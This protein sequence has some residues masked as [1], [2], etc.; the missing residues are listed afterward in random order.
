MSKLKQTLIQIRFV[1]L[2]NKPFANLYHEVRVSGDKFAASAGKSN[3]KGLG[4]WIEKPVGTRLDILVR[5][6]LTKKLISAKH[7]VIVP[8]KKGVFR[9]QAPFSIQTVKLRALE[10][11]AG[12]YKRSTHKVESGT[13]DYKVKKGQDLYTI[14]KMHNTT[15]QILAQLNKATIKDPDKIFSGQIIKVPPKG[16][17]LTGTTNDR[18][19]S[20]KNQTHYKV[21]KG[22]TLSGISQ[23]SSVSVEELKRMNKITDPRTLQEGQTIKLRENGSAQSHTSPKPSPTSTAKPRPTTAPSSSAE[24]NGLFDGVL[25]T[26]TDIAKGTVGAIG[27]A[28]EW[29][30]D[31][32]KEGFEGVTDAMSGGKNDE[33]AG[34]APAASTNAKIKTDTPIKIPVEQEYS[35]KDGTPKVVSGTVCKDDPACIF[36]GKSATAA[37]KKLI[38]EVNIRLAGFGGALPTEEFTEL[39]ERCIKQFQ[40][41][42]M[43]APETGKICGSLIKAID[44]FNYEY[45]IGPY[46]EQMKCPCGQCSGF[47]NGRMGVPSGNN[48]ANEYPGIHRSII[49]AFKA[50]MFYL[51]FTNLGYKALLVSSGYRCIVRNAQKKRT[52][53]NHMGQAL[54]VQFSHISNG[55]IANSV[56]DVE[57]IREVVLVSYM[58]AEYRWDKKN[59][60]SLETTADGASSWVHF[61]SREYELKYKKLN[62]YAKTIAGII[63]GDLSTHTNNRML[64]CGG[65]FIIK[66]KSQSL[67]SIGGIV[68]KVI[69]SHESEGGRYDIFNRG[70]VGDYAWTSG[71]EDIGNRTIDEWR[72]LGTLSGDNKAKRFAMGKYQIIPDTLGEIQKSLKL[73]GSTKLTPETQEL[74]FLEHFIKKTNIITAIKSGSSKDI[75]SAAM[76]IAKIWASVGVPSATSRAAY[77]KVS[78]KSVP[79]TIRIEKDQS[80]WSG[81][82]GNK[83]HTPSALVIKALEDMNS[84]Y[85]TLISQGSSSE[86]AFEKIMSVDEK[87]F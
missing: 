3:A 1:D 59:E 11:S 50:C 16:S 27:G 58:G 13:D 74:M 86:E 15:W 21:K 6:P 80:Y 19:D 82:G 52:S 12:S 47:G 23:R 38:L 66:S 87:L 41:D 32:A 20:L 75:E 72:K 14:A 22:E 10:K 70:T 62:F 54:D 84:D 55:T 81:T 57:K 73:S 68:G 9:V 8:A 39:T 64:A 48:I 85:K 35:S 42:Y 2:M 28:A 65:D 36:K 17:S 77:K 44:K 7:H 56:A 51:S 37:E 40:R 71:Y 31:K 79:Y 18:P 83:A 60:I 63:G 69:A 34:E 49:W 53:V 4:V 46:H 24:E 67:K 26:V 45:P 5:H 25:D 30:G 78:G 29:I 76:K 33:P 43:K 61:D